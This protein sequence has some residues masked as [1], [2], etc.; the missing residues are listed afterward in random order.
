ME[1]NQDTFTLYAAKHYENPY[2]FNE[3]EFHKDL[4]KI[5]TIRRMI[6]WHSNGDQ[7]NLHLLI[8][9]VISFYNVFEHHAATNLLSLKVEDWQSI[10]IN[11]ILYFLS[12]PLIEPGEFD[13]LLHRK[14]TQEFKA[15]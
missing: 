10:K 12:L 5:S 8:N 4:G 3:E 15:L 11:S 7:I 2:C 9:N 14:L 6:S 1:L 13:L